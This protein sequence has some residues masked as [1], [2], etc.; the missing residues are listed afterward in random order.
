MVAS[1]L[2]VGGGGVD[3]LNGEDVFGWYG[4]GTSPTGITS[5]QSHSGLDFALPRAEIHGTL[6][7]APGQAEAWVD[8]SN[9]PLCALEGFRPRHYQNA[10]GPYA[11]NG[12]YPGIYCVSA[13]GYVL[14]GPNLR[15]CFGDPLCLSPNRVFLSENDV[16]NGIDLD[17]TAVAPVERTSWGM[18]KSR[19]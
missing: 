10:S 8:V 11:I 18:L 16:R 12:I 13:G 19:Y 15:V 4:G 7:F 17:F 5:A 3:S 6:T 1:F 2:D 9:D 14:S